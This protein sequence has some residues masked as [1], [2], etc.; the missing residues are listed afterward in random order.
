MSQND[1]YNTEYFRFDCIFKCK[2]H[3]R[4]VIE[5]KCGYNTVFISTF[6]ST[7]KECLIAYNSLL[8]HCSLC[9]ILL[10]FPVM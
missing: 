7:F 9:S 10:F 5:S 8:Q 3:K 4:Y 6:F 2:I 1:G